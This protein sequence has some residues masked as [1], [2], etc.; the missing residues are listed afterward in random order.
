M[1]FAIRAAAA[2]FSARTGE[3]SLTRTRG[4]GR[5]ETTMKRMMARGA[6]LLKEKS[7]V[8]FSAKFSTSQVP[9]AMSRQKE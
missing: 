2:R 7:L 4:R 6:R 3:R 1:E 8:L 5:A 9:P